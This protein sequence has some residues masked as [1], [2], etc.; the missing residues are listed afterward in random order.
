MSAAVVVGAGLAAQAGINAQLRLA[1]GSAL[2]ASILSSASTVILLV[3][4]QLLVRDP[5]QV[6]NLSRY[7]WWIW[8]GGF[9]GAAYVFGVVF[10]TRYLGVAALFIAIVVGQLLAG[11][12]IDHFGW[13]NVPVQRITVTRFAGAMLLLAGM[14]LIRWR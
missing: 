4:A 3:A 11:L 5:L 2:W 12:L 14:G 8:I 1:T 7:P 13:F 9:M 10:L 6:G